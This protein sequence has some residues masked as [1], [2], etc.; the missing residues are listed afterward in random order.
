ML[1]KEMDTMPRS[2]ALTM[3]VGVLIGSGFWAGLIALI[4][5]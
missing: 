4:L 1:R 3:M 5:R 2:L